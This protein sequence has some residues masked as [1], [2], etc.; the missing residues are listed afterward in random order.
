MKW[1]LGL[2]FYSSFVCIFNPSE[3]EDPKVREA[4]QNTRCHVYLICKRKKLH[5]ESSI[6]ENG[7][8]YTTLFY[9]NDKLDKEYL[10]Y[11]HKLSELKI[12]S[13][14]EGFYNIDLAKNKN[15]TVKDYIAIN[16]F[17]FQ[18]KDLI[19][20]KTIGPLPTDLEVMYIGQAFGRNDKKMID[21][22]L[23]NH[24]K[25]QK[26][27]IEILNKSTNE[28][29]LIIGLEIKTNDLSM[30]FVRQGSNTERPT[31]DSLRQ[32]KDKASKRVSEGQEITIFEAS[33]IKYFQTKLN[34]EYKETFPSP[35]FKSYDEIYDT[36]FNYIAMTIETRPVGVRIY[37]NEMKERKYLH[38]QHFPISS[39]SDKKSLF[40]YLLE[41]S[42]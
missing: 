20:D 41:F 2:N 25:I 18:E 32:L 23:V 19:G 8:G 26:I 37:S 30:S 36:D 31:A 12:N 11:Q 24:D 38:A 15:I 17:G 1:T 35:D 33:L 40:E 7:I 10:R 27:A 16:N 14:N 29:V 21:Y 42:N 3:L 4:I 28:E 13:Y 34:V 9:L 5:F 22:R 6:E 39:K